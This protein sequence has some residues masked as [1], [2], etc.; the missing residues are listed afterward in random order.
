MNR[1]LL[2]MA[3]V[4]GMA[5]VPAHAASTDQELMTNN[6]DPGNWSGIGRDFALT[7]HSPLEG[8][9][10]DNVKNLKMAWEMKTGATRGHE[11]QPL[12]I[13]E[14]MYMVS[15]YPNHVY[16]ID[17]SQ[18]DR[19]KVLWQYTPDQDERAV[20]VACCDTVNRGLS[21]ANGSVVF[22]SLSGEVI[23]LDAKTGEVDWK[24][25]L[26]YP[27]KGET[28]TM[29]PII[30]DGKVIAG[31]S[32]NEFG[33]RGRVVAYDLGNGNEVW[34]CHATGTDDDICLG[35]DYN[36]ANPQFGQRGDLGIK[37]YPGEEWQ[38]GGGAAWG[39]YSYDPKL[40][41]VYYGTGNPG[42][43]SPSY[44]CAADNHEACNDGQADNKW[45]MT[46]FARKVD[47]GEAVWGYQK[48]PF[49]QW[50]YDGINEPILVD[51]TI[52]G[53][54]VPALVQF[55]RNG[56]AYVHDRRDGT[57]LRA[58]KFVEVNWA[59]RVDM[60]TGRPVK[61]EAHSP[62]ARGKNVMAMPSAMGGKDQQPCSVD[63]NRP[64]IFYCPTNNWHMELDPQERG[65][66]MQ[67]LPYV[68]ANVLMKPNKP[69]ALGVVK[70]FDVVSGKTLWEREEK[71]PT[72]S[73]TLVTDGGLVFYGTLDGWFRAVNSETGEE[74]WSKKLPSGVIGNPIAYEANGEEYVAVYSGV[75]G[76]IGLP[77]TAGLDPAD[78]YGALGAAGLAFSN[79]F[80]QIPL[81]GM[82]HTFRIGGAGNT[83]EAPNSDPVDPN[84][85]AAAN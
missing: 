84:A 18:T 72:W 55:D 81:G 73:G 22:G 2:T 45:S 17:V 85:Q 30:A 64:N 80:D 13:D 3:L 9:N 69:G 33:V 63:P 78:P 37:T 74:L 36:K 4:A 39:W 24:K 32:G 46:T 21:Y 53:K 57:L 34:T 82:V 23:A 40:Q 54:Q 26:A 35:E 79:D 47:T 59:E 67:G 65:A 77:I 83:V 60:E 1:S 8:I 68:F 56:F 71:F 28:I 20:A 6:Q 42:L 49:D 43:W 76:W 58:H 75:G 25:K 11:G 44:R 5:V 19:G 10:R 48:T 66:T 31:I 15:A 51:L 7:R 14:V 27:E 70:A 41:L 61:V 50:D 62:F 12:V 29:A 38:R 52:D 16:A